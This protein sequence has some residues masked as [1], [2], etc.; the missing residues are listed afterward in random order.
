ME[1]IFCFEIAVDQLKL[2]R[3]VPCE[4]PFIACAFLDF[5]TILV[6]LDN[7]KYSEKNKYTFHKGKSCLFKMS[8]SELYQRL[9]KTPLYLIVLDRF[10]SDQRCIG[11]T[12]VDLA[13]TVKSI[14]GDLQTNGIHQTSCHGNTEA[15]VLFNFMQTTVGTLTVAYKLTSLGHSIMPHLSALDSDKNTTM[16]PPKVK[17]QTFADKA[18]SPI[19]NIICPPPLFYA[20]EKRASPNPQEQSAPYNRINEKIQKTSDQPDTVEN[21]RPDTVEA[22]VPNT[23]NSA[24]PMK[25]NDWSKHP[26]TE[27]L[28]KKQYISI[29]SLSDKKCEATQTE[30]AS[31]L[32]EY[33]IL[34]GLIKEVLKLGLTDTG[35]DDNLARPVATTPVVKQVSKSVKQSTPIK[36]KSK[37]PMLQTYTLNKHISAVEQAQKPTGLSV[38]K[39]SKQLKSKK[40]GSL[41]YGYTKS[42]LLRM[43]FNKKPEEVDVVK[44]KPKKKKKLRRRGLQEPITYMS[45]LSGISPNLEQSVPLSAF[46]STL[47]PASDVSD[48]DL[49]KIDTYSLLLG[50]ASP[51]G[52]SR[53]PSAERGQSRQSIEIRLPTAA[54]VELEGSGSKYKYSDDFDDEHKS[55]SGVVSPTLNSSMRIL[56]SEFDLKTD[57]ENFSPIQTTSDVSPRVSAGGRK[58]PIMESKFEYPEEEEEE[59]HELSPT[60]RS[61]VG[62]TDGDIKDDTDDVGDSVKYEDSLDKTSLNL[63]G[64]SSKL[65]PDSISESIS[66]S[67]YESNFE[68]PSKSIESPPRSVDSPG[69]SVESPPKSIESTPKTVASLP[70]SVEIGP[71]SIETPSPSKSESPSKS[72]R[73]DDY[74]K[75]TDDSVTTVVTPLLPVPAPSDSPVIR[76]LVSDTGIRPHPPSVSSNESKSSRKHVK[77]Q[78]LKKS[79]ESF[80][81]SGISD[82]RTSE[83]GD[84][85]TSDISDF[86]FSEELASKEDFK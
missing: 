64:L 78:F 30:A 33:P 12:S 45:N 62:F 23:N 38:R 34:Q 59:I 65:I 57:T 16:W 60:T 41:Q 72:S 70:K 81:I 50:S 46:Q 44:T 5:P 2:R 58:S 53:P 71:L 32:N 43:E 66:E 80:R 21:K 40:V 25:S 27:T 73:F 18:L 6:H 22:E 54:S 29:Q 4:I 82:I 86:N 39:P 20:A 7:A 79:S 13:P 19:E 49:D 47:L 48:P 24:V 35:S 67:P 17:A 28:P 11:S 85:K 42:M 83:L 56:S 1:S 55:E 69:K 26:D 36:S 37:S 51:V 3:K 68:S 8:P 9:M 63:R 76:S 52:E 31:A 77:R 15:C 84:I 75:P 10:H 14:V 61:S 74:S